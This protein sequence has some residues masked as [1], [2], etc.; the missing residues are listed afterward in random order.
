RRYKRTVYWVSM[1]DGLQRVLLFT[2]DSYL[3]TR[4]RKSSE[5]EPIKMEV[6][7]SLDGVGLSLV[8]NKPEEVSYITLS[9]S[10]SIWQVQKSPGRWKT[11]NL[12]L[13]SWLEDA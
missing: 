7:V 9:S 12:E 3:A 8:N 11:L 4:A 13:S 10:T 5:C 2:E 1:L 6:F